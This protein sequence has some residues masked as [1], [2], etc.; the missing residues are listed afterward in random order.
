MPMIDLTYLRGSLGQQAL[1]RLTDEL[2][3]VP[4]R[5]SSRKANKRFTSGR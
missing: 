3:T 2:V 5:G 4:L 1:G